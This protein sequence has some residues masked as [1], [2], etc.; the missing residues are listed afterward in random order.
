MPE[1]YGDFTTA[2]IRWKLW[3]ERGLWGRIL[4]GLGHK[5]LP[6]PVTKNRN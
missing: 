2:F 6:G 1:D 4:E 5:N 3:K